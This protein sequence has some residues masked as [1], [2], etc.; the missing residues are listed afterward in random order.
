[1]LLV[2]RG[3]EGERRHRLPLPG[4]HPDPAVGARRRRRCRRAVLVG[5]GAEL[6]QPVEQPERGVAQGARQ[7]GLQVGRGI[8]LQL[9]EQPRDLAAGEPQVEQSEEERDRG[10]PEGGEGDQPN[11]LDERPAQEPAD[12]EQRQHDQREAERVDDE[13]RRPPPQ[14]L[15]T[16]AAPVQQDGSDDEAASHQGE[17]DLLDDRP[18]GWRGHH[19][20]EAVGVGAEQNLDHLQ[21]E[22]DRVRRGDER[23]FDLVAEAPGG[24]GEEDVEEQRRRQHVQEVADAVHQGLARPLHGR[25]PH[26]EPGEHH[27]RTEPAG[28]STPPGQDA[29]QDVRDDDPCDEEDP[30]GRLLQSRAGD[31]EDE[32]PGQDGQAGDRECPEHPGSTGWRLLDHGSR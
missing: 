18:G 31:A 17:L 30:Q 6:G 11:R 25:E 13:G 4:Q 23:P 28:R 1:V 3:V 15:V 20:E 24:E 2:E 26:D 8:G 14:P 29:A 16:R 5:P 22:G 19:D 7:R 10:Q 9:D 21:A 27:Q 12:V 32:D